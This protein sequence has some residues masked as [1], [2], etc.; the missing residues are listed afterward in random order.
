MRVGL[1]AMCAL[2]S[3]CGVQN[4]FTGT[5]DPGDNLIAPELSLDE[6][7]FFCRIEPDVIQQFSCATGTGSDRGGCHDSR[8]ALR[9]IASEE[10]PPCDS[11]GRVTGT[12]PDAY[13]ANL[14]AAR[15]FVQADPLTSPL[16]LR[17]INQA[18]HPRQIFGA[19]DAAAKLIEEWISAGATN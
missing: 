4:G 14:E 8:S 2:A 19:Q 11:S 10:A 17:P 15:F 12:I 16:Y 7:F 5:V 3:A 1:L 6:D 9:L 18:S 13:A